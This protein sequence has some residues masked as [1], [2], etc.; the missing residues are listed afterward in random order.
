MEPTNIPYCEIILLQSLE[1]G[2]DNL[3]DLNAI[4]DN[5][6]KYDPIPFKKLTTIK[7]SRYKE[8]I[9]FK[10]LFKL[11]NNDYAYKVKRGRYNITEKGS[12]HLNELNTGL[13]LI[14]YQTII[15][16]TVKEVDALVKSLTEQIQK[17][18]EED[19]THPIKSKYLQKN[20]QLKEELSA[21]FN[22]GCLFS[23]TDEALYIFTM[24]P[25]DVVPGTILCQPDI[26]VDTL[27]PWID[28]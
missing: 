12:L 27:G 21:F 28:L 4:F 11:I 13:S 8:D 2:F 24:K 16:N 17:R 1:L 26:I 6:I 3:T 20:G 9:I 22:C 19:M 14:D 25:I 18:E 5:C 15:K 23:V 7:D 10:L